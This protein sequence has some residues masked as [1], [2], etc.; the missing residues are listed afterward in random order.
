[1]SDVEGIIQR[2]EK[3]AK[4]P[5]A[6]AVVTAP[7]IQVRPLTTVL[8]LRGY[9]GSGPDEHDSCAGFM[10]SHNSCAYDGALEL[11]Y[12][13]FV[14]D[15]EVWIDMT[16]NITE[17]DIGLVEVIQ[18]FIWRRDQVFLGKALTRYSL[19]LQHRRTR[20]QTSLA[21][22]GLATAVGEYSSPK[23]SYSV[24][25]ICLGASTNPVE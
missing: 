4:A 10:W 1:M 18:L 25:Y 7:R 19:D 24:I 21:K 20:L 13:V 9:S 12:A 16:K 11:L 3:E 14:R 15:P 22:R 8:S 17:Y 2:E 5:G 6:P 23:V